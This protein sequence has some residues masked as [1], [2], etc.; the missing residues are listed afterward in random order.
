MI[1]FQQVQDTVLSLSKDN[2]KALSP[3][4]RGEG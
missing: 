4:G 3:E 2:V 1:I